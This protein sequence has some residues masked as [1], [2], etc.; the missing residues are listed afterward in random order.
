MTLIRR[1][2]SIA[3][4][5]ALLA[6]CASTG[7][8]RA[9]VSSA[10]TEAP[11]TQAPGAQAGTAAADSQDLS[12]YDALDP[13]QPFNRKAH[14]FN[15][16]IDKILLRPVAKGYATVTPRIVRK[17]ISNFFGNLQQP[18]T[19]LNL[20]LQGQGKDAGKSFGRFLMNLT[21]G[22]GGILD[23]ATHAGIPYYD[24]DFG[25]T[26]T[27][28]GWEESR[29][30]VLPIFGPGTVRDGLGKG[31]STTVSPISWFADENGA[32]YSILYGIDARASA[33][34]AEAFLKGAP[35]EYLLIR[36]AYLQ[37]RRCQISDC[38]EDVPDYLNPDYEFEIPDFETLRR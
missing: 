33:L 32:E 35:D 2:A 36:D 8:T 30:L 1:S 13:W 3:L 31:V 25:Q 15:S 7:G 27:V 19:S 26:F 10:A 5:L 14:A 12:S 9:D 21:L 22:L 38:S 23:P 29:Y 4:V 16:A 18:V 17:G 6:G 24:Q 28:W 11:A 37:R 20:L 34:P